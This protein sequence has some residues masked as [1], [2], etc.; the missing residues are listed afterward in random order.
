[1]GRLNNRCTYDL[2]AHVDRQELVEILLDDAIPNGRSSR[3]KVDRHDPR[4]DV[5]LSSD[6]CA[7][8]RCGQPKF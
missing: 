6:D 5:I 8:V 4:P 7:N 1:L 3:R 2:P